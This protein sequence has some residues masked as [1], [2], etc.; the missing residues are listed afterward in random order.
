MCYGITIHVSSSTCMHEMRGP[1]G[2]T[3]PTAHRV[4]T[5]QPLPLD[6]IVLKTARQTLSSSS[7]VHNAHAR[8]SACGEAPPIRDGAVSIP[9]LSFAD[10]LDTRGPVG[11]CKLSLCCRPK[12]LAWPCYPKDD[13]TASTSRRSHSW[14]PVSL[15]VS[16]LPRQICLE[17][18]PQ[19]STCRPAAL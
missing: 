5:R 4:F 18:D 14:S 17:L 8:W 15:L 3:V 12:A 19:V 7:A 6:F 2:S 10:S 11:M 16:L 13:I 9:N 1:V